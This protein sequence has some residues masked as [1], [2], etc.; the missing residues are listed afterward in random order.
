VPTVDPNEFRSAYRQ[1]V[2]DVGAT[3]PAGFLDLLGRHD[4]GLLRWDA[5]QYMTLSERRYTLALEMLGRFGLA[6]EPILEV[7]GFLATFPLT[8][9]RLDFPVT[10]VERYDLYEGSLDGVRELLGRAGATV[11]DVD[12]TTPTQNVGQFPIVLNMAMIEHLAGSPRVVMHNLRA[13]CDRLLLL[14]VPNIAYAYK[15]WD[16]LRGRTVHPRLTEVFESKPPFTGHY[17]EYTIAEVEELLQLS[18]F[19]SKAI[20]TFSYS[21]PDDWRSVLRP[22]S[23][24]ARAF[25]GW[26]EVIMAVAAPASAT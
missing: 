21:I 20:E 25:R 1:A 17:R 3:L 7:G 12:F 5:R 13:A 6:R 16:L 4:P 2:A 8:L 22:Q 24:A 26:R 9:A 23:L 15:R 19:E 14:E 11:I 18:G 10:V